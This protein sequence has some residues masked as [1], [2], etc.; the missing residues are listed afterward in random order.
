MYILKNSDPF[1]ILIVSVALFVGIIYLT[2]A[3]YSIPQLQNI[4]KRSWICWR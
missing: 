1:V 2:K 3:K 4:R